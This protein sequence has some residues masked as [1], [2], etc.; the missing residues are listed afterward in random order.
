[1]KS[2]L[3]IENNNYNTSGH[4]PARLSAKIDT[5]SE[6]VI[7]ATGFCLFESCSVVVVVS[8]FKLIAQ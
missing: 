5:S 8:G 1:M 4:S 2:P 6:S 3:L 7:G